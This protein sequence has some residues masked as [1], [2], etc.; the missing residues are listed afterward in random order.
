MAV[1]TVSVVHETEARMIYRRRWKPHV[2]T[3]PVWGLL[4]ISGMDKYQQAV[5]ARLL[6][7]HVH[8]FTIAHAGNKLC[9]RKPSY[10]LGRWCFIELYACSAGQHGRGRP[11]QPPDLPYLQQHWCVL[12][13]GSCC[14]S[15]ALS[16]GFRMHGPR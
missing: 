6:D 11:R 12:S 15:V 7:T 4:S 14:S 1:P 3:Y 8:P 10:A 9:L 2:V 16:S 13:S 5:M